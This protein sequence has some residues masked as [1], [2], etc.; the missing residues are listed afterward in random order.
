MTA[1]TNVSQTASNEAES[2]LSADS[3][4]EYLSNHSDFFEQR[5]D[6]LLSLRLPHEQ[7][8]S[9]SLFE[10]QTSLM[11]ERESRHHNQIKSLLATAKRN[12]QLLNHTREL[13]VRLLNAENMQDVIEQ[14]Q[15]CFLEQFNMD[16]AVI[17]AF[18]DE[19]A[20]LHSSVTG[21]LHARKPVLGTLRP[22]ELE[23]L[24]PGNAEKIGSAAVYSL[25][26][27]SLGTELGILALASKDQRYFDSH[28]DSLFLEF[29][30]DTLVQLFKKYSS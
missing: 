9:I 7:K 10:K 15:N 24:F 30:G 8:N 11:R 19:P 5:P 22:E 17:T 18:G 29:V 14:T 16:F 4:A 20:E 27:E 6:L 25:R 13:V 2:T 12:D 23:F 28:M 3:V 1:N 21:L 26:D